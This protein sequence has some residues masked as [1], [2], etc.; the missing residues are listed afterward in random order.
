MQLAHSDCHCP[1]HEEVVQT[2]YRSDFYNRFNLQR[3]VHVMVYVLQLKQNFQELHWEQ[4]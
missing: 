1:I 2:R 4:V 3:N